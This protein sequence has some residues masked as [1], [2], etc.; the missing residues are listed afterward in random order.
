MIKAK[1]GKLVVNGHPMEL[2]NE[3]KV[4][5][6]QMVEMLEDEGITKENIKKIMTDIVEEEFMTEEERREKFERLMKEALGD[7]SLLIDKVLGRE[8]K[9][10][11]DN[12]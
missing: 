3:Y 5:T 8:E 1:K 12:E 7:M 2:L 6:K 11:A 9:D 10:G 4:I